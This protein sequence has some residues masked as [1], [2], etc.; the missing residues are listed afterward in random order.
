MTVE[1]TDISFESGN[2][3]EGNMILF[4]LDEEGEFYKDANG[5]FTMSNIVFHLGE[6]VKKD[7]K[8]DR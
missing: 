5:N 1:V 6:I 7:L 8:K 4:S 2:D 3:K